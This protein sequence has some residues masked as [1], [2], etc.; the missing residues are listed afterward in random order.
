MKITFAS[1]VLCMIIS[2]SAALAQADS[3]PSASSMKMEMHG[4]A[5]SGP[6]VV[7]SLSTDLA[8]LTS[9]L[10]I[11]ELSKIAQNPVLES[12]GTTRSAKD[13]QL[14]RTISPS[15]V[16]VAN[17]DSFGSGSLLDPREIF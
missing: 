1:S 3:F 11:N 2:S 10:P 14:Y 16:L 15:V 17:K 9:D 5:V 7:Q 12:S 4:T 13:A 8:E 6:R